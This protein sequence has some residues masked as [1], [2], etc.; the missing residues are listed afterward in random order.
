MAERDAALSTSPN[1]TI[2]TDKIDQ[3]DHKD[4][5]ISVAKITT[6]KV[7]DPQDT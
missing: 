5:K 6:S 4:F 2:M 1:S 7:E 3:L